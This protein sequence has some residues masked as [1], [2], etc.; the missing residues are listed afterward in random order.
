MTK[1]KKKKQKKKK[2][3]KEYH[4]MTITMKLTRNLIISIMNLLQQLKMT[5]IMSKK[6]DNQEQNP[7]K[8][9]LVVLLPID[10]VK[11]KKDRK[12]TSKR[13]TIEDY[14]F[15]KYC[16]T[17]LSNGPYNDNSLEPDRKSTS[18]VWCGSS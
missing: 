10:Q 13:R 17:Y 9:E 1:K 18:D 6:Q 14:D 16:K 7:I 5:L 3:W 11:K 8:Q 12:E 2:T 4:K 15:T